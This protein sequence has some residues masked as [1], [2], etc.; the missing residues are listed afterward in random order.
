MQFLQQLNIQ[1]NNTGVSTGSHWLPTTGE[2]ITS[3]SP[4]D[5]QKIAT[6][7]SADKASYEQAITKAQ[8]AFATWR[9]WPAPKR[10][11]IVRQVGDALRKNKEPLGKLVSYEM[12]KS[13]QEG[14]GRSAGNDRYLR[15]CCW[16][17]AAIAWPN[18]AQRTPGP[19]YVRAM[20]SVGHCGYY[21]SLQLSR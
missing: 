7:S 10:G 20:A 21:F 5:G 4:V 8:E 18:H 15:F 6:V 1:E 9:T 2:T 12:G 3:F 11:E 13:L 19:P 17:F 14:Y 16:S